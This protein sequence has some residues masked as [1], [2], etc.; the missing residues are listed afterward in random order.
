MRLGLRSSRPTLRLVRGVVLDMEGVLHVDWEPLPGAGRA[1]R[2]LR[3]AGHEVC[4]L[5]NTTTRT[6]EQISD[7]LAG[8]GVEI[9][10]AR[11]VTAASATAELL[12]RRF[13]GARVMLLAER[14]AEEEFAGVQL[15]ERGPV[16]VVAVGGP[17]EGFGYERLDRA[18]RALH[19]GARLVAMHENR[20]WVTRSGPRLDAGAYVRGL[21]YAAGARPLVVGKPSPRIFRLACELLG[22]PPR[23]CAMVGDDLRSDVLPA[24][25]AGLGGVLVRTGKGARHEAEDARVVEADAVLDGISDLP[26]WLAAGTAG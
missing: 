18:F 4:V 23:R 14:G 19:E 25:R 26:G 9:A 17:D 21:A 20:W 22:V 12:R 3:S 11:I 8:M 24:R 7:A 16:D 1:V 10:P 5:T 2:A 13:A 15:V 6:R